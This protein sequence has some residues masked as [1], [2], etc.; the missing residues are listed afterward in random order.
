MGHGW[1]LTQLQEKWSPQHTVNDKN[2]YSI[3]KLWTM[4]GT[5]VR[6]NI[7]YILFAVTKY[8]ARSNLRGERVYPGLQFEEIPRQWPGEVWQAVG[9]GSFRLQSGSR[10]R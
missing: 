3:S 2:R 7:G 10:G 6:W 4:F 1:R 9:A 8:L 5:T